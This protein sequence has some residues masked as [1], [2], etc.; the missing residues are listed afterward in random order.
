MLRPFPIRSMPQIP[1]RPSTFIMLHLGHVLFAPCFR[2]IPALASTGK[3][4]MPRPDLSTPNLSLA[5]HPEAQQ[6]A[7]IHSEVPGKEKNTNEKCR[8]REN[9]RRGILPF[10]AFPN[11]SFFATVVCCEFRPIRSISLTFAFLLSI[12][13]LDSKKRTTWYI[14]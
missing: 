3:N 2:G 13:Q 9:E 4:A 6:E 8:T 1:P 11:L 12:S 10:L 14:D 5:Q 7:Q